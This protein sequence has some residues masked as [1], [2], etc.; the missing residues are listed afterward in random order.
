MALKPF[1]LTHVLRPAVP[2]LHVK[3]APWKARELNGEQQRQG[4]TITCAKWHRRARAPWR[5]RNL[6]FQIFQKG[7]DEA[8]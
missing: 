6:Y 1:K 8:R 2:S 7:T 4:G 5:S 3:D